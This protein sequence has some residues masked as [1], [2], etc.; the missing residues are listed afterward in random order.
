MYNLCTE[1]KKKILKTKHSWSLSLEFIY[2]P[3]LL[4][5]QLFWRRC[6]T[7][8][9]GREYALYNRYKQVLTVFKDDFN[10][11]RINAEWWNLITLTPSTSSPTSDNRTKIHC[12]VI[13][14]DRG[15]VVFFTNDVFSNR[16][17]TT[18][19]NLQYQ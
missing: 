16:Q 10:M 18:T 9:R 8:R 12:P 13:V 6:R 3:Y 14:S 17:I 19:N 15:V 1:K 2:A 4:Y 7:V 5:R 11:T